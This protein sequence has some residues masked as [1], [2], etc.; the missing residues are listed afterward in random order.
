MVSPFGPK[1][2]NLLQAAVPA[3][4]S[5]GEDDQRG[6]HGSRRCGAL[7]WT[8]GDGEMMP[9]KGSRRSRIAAARARLGDPREPFWGGENTPPTT[10]PK[11]AS[12][13][14]RPLSAFPRL[15]PYCLALTVALAAC[16][17]TDDGGTDQTGSGGTTGT[18]GH[19]GLGGHLGDR[20]N[21]PAPREPPAPRDSPGR[22]GSPAPPGR[23]APPAPRARPAPPASASMLGLVVCGLRT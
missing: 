8:R 12:M 20:W 19:R 7:N 21:P 17:Q 23:R 4:H 22:R 1:R 2:W 16:A 6:I 5:C 9:T 11:E 13:A 14:L 18:R 15:V 10:P 3:T